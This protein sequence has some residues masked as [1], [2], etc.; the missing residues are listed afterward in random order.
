MEKKRINLSIESPEVI[1]WLEKQGNQTAAIN[2]VL[3]AVVRHQELVRQESS[4]RALK[5]VVGHLRTITDTLSVE[6][7]LTAF[8]N[9]ITDLEPKDPSAPKA[10]RAAGRTRFQQEPLCVE[11]D[12]DKN[13]SV[14]IIDSSGEE[15]LFV[16]PSIVVFGT[17][18]P[19]SAHNFKH[20]VGK[21]MI[22]SKSPLQGLSQ[23]NAC[24]L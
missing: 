18:S 16:A 9:A 13:F 2:N 6:T 20:T 17:D 24:F 10:I 15:Q 23:V 3:E 22:G 19:V 4:V 8:E 7:L 14:V 21:S 12:R 1:E 11:F 5:C